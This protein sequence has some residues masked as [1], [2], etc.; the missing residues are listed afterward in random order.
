MSLDILDFKVTAFDYINSIYLSEVGN[1]KRAANII[2]KSI[3]NDGVTHVFGTGHSFGFGM[4]LANRAGGL[5][6]F[7]SIGIDELFIYGDAKNKY[8][9]R[10]EVERN[11][12]LAHKI[13]EINNIKN[14]DTFILV[15]NSGINGTIVE[16]GL[17]IKKMGIPLIVVTSLKHTSSCESRHPSHNKLIDLADVVIDNKAPKGDACFITPQIEDVGHI[18]GISSITGAFI[19]Q[20]ICIEVINLS[21]KRGQ[22]PPV[23]LSANLPGSDEHNALLRQKYQDSFGRREVVGCSI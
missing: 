6:P 11:P 1:I 18:C 16:M 12:N 22:K 23:L 14:Q 19:A 2:D 10:E 13:I 8:Y 17:A 21:L 3:E 9:G 15:S 5:I 4:E 7:N 20:S